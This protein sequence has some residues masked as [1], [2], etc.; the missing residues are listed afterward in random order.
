M[1]IDLKISPQRCTWAD[2]EAVAVAAEGSGLFEGLW[3]FDHLAPVASGGG[4]PGD[5]DGCFEGWTVLAALAARTRRCRLG[6]LVSSV[7][8]RNI[9]VTA[10]TVTTIDHISSGR[11]EVG[12]GAGNT[13]SEAE[14]FG[15]PF[16]PVRARVTLL[17]E[18]LRVLDRLL[19]GD[20]VTF[21]GEH[22]RVH[23][24]RCAPRPCQRRVPIIVG[25]KGERRTIPATARHAT[26][27]NYSRGTPEE[28]AAKLAVLHRH[29]EA[30]GRDP[31]DLRASV[32]VRVDPATTD[33]ATRL[34]EAYA[35][36]GASDVV[37]YVNAREDQFD[38][39]CTVARRLGA[40]TAPAAAPLGE[41]EEAMCP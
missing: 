18:H 39:A 28:F 23:E 41:D 25:G 7:P 33:A 3:A 36:A 27:W 9:G 11:V 12:L 34:A 21:A 2:L 14:A 4:D 15:L 32:Q 8:Y 5:P 40:P 10:Q 24:A 20:T 38:A 26:G 19:A 35:A 17:E 13:A 16:G 37:L 1:R 22:V 31:A 6:L 29:A 30:A